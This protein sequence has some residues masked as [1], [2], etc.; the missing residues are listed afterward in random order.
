MSCCGRCRSKL[1]NKCLCPLKMGPTL[2]FWLA[3]TNG[4]W[5]TTFAQVRAAGRPLLPDE[6]DV[7][8]CSNPTTRRGFPS[9]LGPLMLRP[10]ALV[11]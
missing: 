3:G 6:D 5:F 11:H 4:T 10:I 1:G 7:S 2:D 9:P 8:L